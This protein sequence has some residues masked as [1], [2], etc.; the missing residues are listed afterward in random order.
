VRHD[1]GARHASSGALSPSSPAAARRKERG[2]T[3]PGLLARE[4]AAQLVAEQTLDGF[5]EPL[6]GLEHDVAREPVA[7]HVAAPL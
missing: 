5:D 3:A 7:H 2:A 1:G 4:R 6:G